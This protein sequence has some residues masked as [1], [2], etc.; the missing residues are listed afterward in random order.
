MLLFSADRGGQGETVLRS[1]R[2]QGGLP[3]VRP[4]GGRGNHSGDSAAGTDLCVC[5]GRRRQR[6]YPQPGQLYLRVQG[7]LTTGKI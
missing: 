2:R 5:T 1:G 4:G 7:R 6:T 3:A